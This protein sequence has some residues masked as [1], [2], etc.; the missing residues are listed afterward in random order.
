MAGQIKRRTKFAYFVDKAQKRIYK[1]YTQYIRYRRVMADDKQ[2]KK[3]KKK[4]DSQLIIRVTAE[5]RDAFVEICDR[6]DTS[7]SREVRRFMRE[8]VTAQNT[9]REE[10]K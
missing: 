4:K 3:N 2:K 6:L 8:F 9:A 7:A 1:R 5:E 10:K